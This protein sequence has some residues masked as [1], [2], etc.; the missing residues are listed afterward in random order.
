MQGPMAASVYR[1]RLVSVP[2]GLLCAL[3][4]RLRLDLEI[5]VVAVDCHEEVVQETF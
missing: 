5:S 2:R 4:P 3:E 1:Y